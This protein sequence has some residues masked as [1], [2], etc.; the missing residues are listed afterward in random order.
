MNVSRRVFSLY[1]FPIRF[2]RFSRVRVLLILLPFWFVSV[3][4]SSFVSCTMFV[5]LV[6]SVRLNV[7]FKITMFASIRN[8]FFLI[9][10]IMFT[11]VCFIH[12]V[13]TRAGNV[14]RVLTS[15]TTS[16]TISFWS[17]IRR[18]SSTATSSCCSL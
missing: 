5:R 15:I 7:F 18:I 11:S 4:I 10:P 14:R 13:I 12:N 8:V 17:K 16:V 9:T 6:F 1:V 3:I 2:V